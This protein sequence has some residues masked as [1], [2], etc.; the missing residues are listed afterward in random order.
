MGTYRVDRVVAA[1]SEQS[2]RAHDE[3]RHL[4]LDGE[5]DKFMANLSPCRLEWQQLTLVAAFQLT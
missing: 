1:C 4:A 2:S 5:N 3:W